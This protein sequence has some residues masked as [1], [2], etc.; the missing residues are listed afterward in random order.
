MRKTSLLLMAALVLTASLSSMMLAGCGTIYEAAMDPRDLGTQTADAKI[1]AKITKAYYDD[2]DMSV[3]SIDPYV[4]NGDVYLVGE[5]ANA[6][7]KA[8]AVSLAKGVEGVRSV[9]TYLLPEKEDPACGTTDNIKVAAKV[10]AA[11]IGDG[12]IWSTNV[13]VKAVQC[14]VVLLGLVGSQQEIDKSIMH[15]RDTDGVRSVHSYLR[16]AKKQ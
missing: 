12:D 6:T 11:L 1:D 3:L 9:T 14:N 13:E 5:Y 2:K 4:F 8:K 16:V 7:Q 10:K 15:A